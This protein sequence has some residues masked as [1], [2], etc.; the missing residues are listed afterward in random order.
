MAIDKTKAQFCWGLPGRK[1]D[2]NIFIVLLRY[3]KFAWQ[4]IGKN[5]GKD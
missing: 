5:T 2:L 3:A 1:R 4:Y